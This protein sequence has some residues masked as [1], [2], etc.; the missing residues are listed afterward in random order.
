[1][2]MGF[3]D[4]GSIFGIKIYNSNDDSENILFEKIYNKMSDEKKKA[5]LFY[6]ELNKE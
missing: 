6:T 1:M 5:Y 2:I 3:Y 4:N